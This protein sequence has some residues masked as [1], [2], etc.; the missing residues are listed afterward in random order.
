[1]L[2]LA[3]DA[4]ADLATIVGVPNRALSLNGTMGLAFGARGGGKFAARTSPVVSRSSGCIQNQ[5]W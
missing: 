5:H 4:L 2:A 1:M 3:Y